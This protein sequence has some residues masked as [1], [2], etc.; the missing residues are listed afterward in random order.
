MPKRSRATLNSI[1]LAKLVA[2]LHKSKGRRSD[3]EARDLVILEWLSKG[4]AE[5]FLAWSG[6][7]VGPDV[8]RLIADMLRRDPDL[9]YHLVIKRRRGAPEKPGMLWRDIFVTMVFEKHCATLSAE[10][11]F[12]E[13]AAALGV[14]VSSIRAAVRRDRNLRKTVQ[15]RQINPD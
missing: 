4:D 15:S 12:A 11:A 14:S 5:P 3:A 10:D 1:A 8:L 9:P 13:T 7:G 2:D 6:E